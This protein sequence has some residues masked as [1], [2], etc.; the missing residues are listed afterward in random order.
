M[1]IIETLVSVAA[2]GFVFLALAAL[3]VIVGIRQEERSWTLAC[4]D[5]PSGVARL[6]RRMLGAHSTCRPVVLL[7][8]DLL[9][10]RHEY[11][12]SR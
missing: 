1:A 12:A 10:D 8:D 11:Q 7:A 4:G 3:V 9:S 2:A 6:A 5:A